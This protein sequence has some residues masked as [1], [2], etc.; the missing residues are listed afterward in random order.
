MYTFRVEGLGVLDESCCVDDGKPVSAFWWGIV[1]YSFYL[2]GNPVVVWWLALCWFFGL[3]G[4]MLG[5][6]MGFLDG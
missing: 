2:F 3:G 6:V 1:C 5:F 4:W